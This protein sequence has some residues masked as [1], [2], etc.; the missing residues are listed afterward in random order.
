[1]QRAESARALLSALWLQGLRDAPR[2][3]DARCAH[4][5]RAPRQNRKFYDGM[6]IQRSDGFVVQSVRSHSAQYP[7][8]TRAY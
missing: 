5:G 8:R 2:R 1:M 3:A 6:E 4:T 7:Q